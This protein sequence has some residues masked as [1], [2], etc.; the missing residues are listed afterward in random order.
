MR[1]ALGQRGEEIAVQYLQNRGYR[2]LGR[3]FR[4]RYGELDVICMKKDVLVFVEVK[5]RR[6]LAYGTAEEALTPAKIEHIRKV[7]LHYL[8]AH[9]VK[10]KEIRFDVIT[11]L[12]TNDEPKLNHI[13]AAF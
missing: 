12:M 3:N 5:T 7:A 4:T 13:T 9:P 11:I 1:K 8:N 10:H 2:I 6:S